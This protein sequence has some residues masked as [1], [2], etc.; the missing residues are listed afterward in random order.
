MQNQAQFEVFLLHL[1]VG[2]TRTFMLDTLRYRKL[3]ISDSKRDWMRMSV[4]FL[5]AFR[6]ANRLE[7]AEE[8][9]RKTEEGMR[10]TNKRLRKAR[11]R[12][13]N[14][15]E[16]AHATP[17]SGPLSLTRREFAARLLF[18]SRLL[19]LPRNGAAIAFSSFVPIPRFLRAPFQHRALGLAAIPHAFKTILRNGTRM[20]LL[21]TNLRNWRYREEKISDARVDP[22]SASCDFGK[23]TLGRSK[24]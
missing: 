9:R 1:V 20:K 18:F 7:G 14:I 4:T 24:G 16:R 17:I 13:P 2:E 5:V 12:I 11:V 10:A 15:A 8:K 23:V 19:Y 21:G 3:E 6:G 22:L